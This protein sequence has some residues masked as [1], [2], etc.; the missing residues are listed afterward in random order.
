MRTRVGGRKVMGDREQSTQV[1]ERRKTG[2]E[3]TRGTD[4]ED[5]SECAVHRRRKEKV[6]SKSFVGDEDEFEEREGG[7]RN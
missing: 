6:M 3:Y 4:R 1:G 5:V 2:D 7:G